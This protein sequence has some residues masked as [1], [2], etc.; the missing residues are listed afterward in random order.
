MSHL[1]NS[2]A[3]FNDS[4]FAVFP[5][6]RHS[7][8]RARLIWELEE[9]AGVVWTHTDFLLRSTAVVTRKAMALCQQNPRMPVRETRSKRPARP[10]AQD[11][12]WSLDWNNLAVSQTGTGKCTETSAV[13]AVWV[14]SRSPLGCPPLV[15]N[16]KH[17]NFAGSLRGN[18]LSVTTTHPTKN[19]STSHPIE[20]TT[21]KMG[22]L[23]VLA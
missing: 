4:N 5:R 18:V 23:V 12:C 10:R 1:I 13:C 2:T 14:F 7:D 17:S 3:V 19:S 22:V 20:T 11:K 9:E 21:K 16:E 8:Q 6:E 15:D